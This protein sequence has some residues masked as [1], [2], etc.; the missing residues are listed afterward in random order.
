VLSFLIDAS[1]LVGEDETTIVVFRDGIAVPPCTGPTGEAVPSP[2]VS[3]R[4]RLPDGDVRLEIRTSAASIWSLGVFTCEPALTC[5]DALLPTKA[6]LKLQ[7]RPSGVAKFLWKWTRGLQLNGPDVSVPATN[8]SLAVCAFGEGAGH[9]P[10]LYWSRAPGGAQCGEAACWKI[11]PTKVSYQDR[12]RARRG[13]KTLRVKTKADGSAQ[14]LV[15]ATGFAAPHL[16]IE[17]V[18]D[19]GTAADHLAALLNERDPPGEL[20]VQLA[21][22]ITALADLCCRHRSPARQW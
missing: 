16:P 12:T 2:C 3:E 20:G 6:V 4:E 5:T 19:G 22:R 18:F 11:S 1:I 13:L 9:A 7:R 15:K 21:G 14:I 10:L 17:P 8:G